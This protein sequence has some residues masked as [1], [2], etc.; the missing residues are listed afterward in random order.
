[1]DGKKIF[2]DQGDDT[3]LM[4]KCNVKSDINKVYWYVNDRFVKA[5][6]ASEAV[7]FKPTAG[8]IKIS[9][10]DDKGNATNINIYVNYQ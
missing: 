4:L 8:A 10:S 7:F 5:A 2:I 1:M 6:K 9:C 3:E